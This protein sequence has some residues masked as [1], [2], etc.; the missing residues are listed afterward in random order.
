MGRKR[1]IAEVVNEH[2]STASE[3]LDQNS[4]Q[5]IQLLNDPQ[6]LEPLH[7]FLNKVQLDDLNLP[8]LLNNPLV[9]ERLVEIFWNKDTSPY[10]LGE[11]A[12]QLLGSNFLNFPISGSYT[13]NNYNPLYWLIQAMKINK[14]DLGIDIFRLLLCAALLQPNTEKSLLLLHRLMT[15]IQEGNAYATGLLRL[16]I[17]CNSPHLQWNAQLNDTTAMKMLIIAIIT[18]KN[19]QGQILLIALNQ[20]PAEHFNKK[21][22]LDLINRSKSSSTENLLITSQEEPSKAQV[23]SIEP[24]NQLAFQFQ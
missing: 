5:F 15:Y 19:S 20:I 2:D 16:L 13:I 6:T 14:M 8:Q 4:E 7:H 10:V 1:K 11:I 12:D 18:N 21:E 17:K 22:A 3:G 23:N 9:V 24:K